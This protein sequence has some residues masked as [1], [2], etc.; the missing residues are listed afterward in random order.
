MGV[1]PV[2]KIIFSRKGFDSTYGGS[3]SPILPD[4]RM[5][6]LPIPDR[7]SKI[8]YEDITWYEY[9]LGELVSVLTRG[10]VKPHYFAHLDPDINKNSLLR[11]PG[12]RPIFG[13]TGPPQGHLRNNLIQTGDI[14][15][16]FGLY[17]KV[18]LSSGKFEWERRSPR[19]H[20]IWGW[21]QID[22]M[23]NVDE[24]DRSKFE[25]ATY[26]PH[27]HRK[28]ETNN[29]IYISREYLTFPGI[30]SSK[31]AGAGVFPRISEKLVLSDPDVP[32]PSIWKLPSWFYPRDGKI[33]LTCHPDLTRWERT[34]DGVRLKTARGQ[35]FV[36]DTDQF[37]EAIGWLREIFL[38]C[39]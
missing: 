38:E 20:I 28:P 36:M 2:M 35:E 17:K 13:Q 31:L 22:E 30:P 11:R 19:R 23:V 12:W 7:K 26:H 18:R 37:H 3:P 6:S 10:R 24:C 27:F 29:T 15:I 8:R 33:P 9:N 39:L 25:W 16:F 34:G 4:G 21:L 32:T 1:R 14:F 5:I